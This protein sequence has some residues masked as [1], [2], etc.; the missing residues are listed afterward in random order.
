MKKQQAWDI[1]AKGFIDKVKAVGDDP[2]HSVLIIGDPTFGSS[3]LKGHAPTPVNTFW[4]EMGAR[5]GMIRKGLDEYNTSQFCSCCHSKLDMSKVQRE[6]HEGQKARL[7]RE[8][9]LQETPTSNRSKEK[10]YKPWG[11]R[12]CTNLQCR[13]FWCRDFNAARCDVD[14][15]ESMLKTRT[16]PM[17][18]RR[19]S[20]EVKVKPSKKR[21]KPGLDTANPQSDPSMAVSVKKLKL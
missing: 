4:K 14:I 11:V 19:A 12:I 9:S 21:K 13:T 20:T 2:K 3:C 5:T 10:S 15:F 6:H 18:F 1:I 16:R 17:V 8:N 7:K